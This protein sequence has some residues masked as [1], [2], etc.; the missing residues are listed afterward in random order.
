MFED[1]RAFLVEETVLGLPE[2]RARANNAEG[3][4]MGS[5]QGPAVL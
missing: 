3:N 1:K 4:R 2:L 5:G